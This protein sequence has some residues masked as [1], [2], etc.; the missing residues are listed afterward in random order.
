MGKIDWQ[1]RF[2]AF[3]GDKL[4]AD[5]NQLEVALKLKAEG[6]EPALRRGEIL[7]FA[8]ADGRQIDLYLSGNEL[9]IERR[10]SVLPQL[11]PAAPIVS[12]AEAVSTGK[13]PGPTQARGN[14]A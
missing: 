3:E 14:R 7:L 11:G 12:S 4:I 8:G 1:N 10:Y 5:G 13:N 2:L 6:A 9:D